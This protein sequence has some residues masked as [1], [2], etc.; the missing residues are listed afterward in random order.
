MGWSEVIGA[1]AISGFPP[2]VIARATRRCA[3]LFNEGMMM[4]TLIETPFDRSED[5]ETRYAPKEIPEIPSDF[6]VDVPD[7]ESEGEPFT[8]KS[9]IRKRAASASQ[10]NNWL[11]VLKGCRRQDKGFPKQHDLKRHLRSAHKL[12]EDEIREELDRNFEDSEVE[13]GVQYVFSIFCYILMSYEL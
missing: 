3:D 4:R 5:F 2:E 1:A 7:H 13:G 8:D 11:C 6:E 12:T 9:K 10:Q